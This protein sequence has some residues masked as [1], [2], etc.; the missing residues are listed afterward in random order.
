MAT[1]N[2]VLICIGCL[3]T[4]CLVTSIF[5]IRQN[6]RQSERIAELERANAEF[7]QRYADC[8]RQLTDVCNTLED[9]N[10]RAGEIARSMAEQLD[11]D[12]GNIEKTRTLVRL[13]REE[14]K[15]LEDSYTSI[16]SSVRRDNDTNSGG[17]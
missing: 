10:R 12:A 6:R 15:V 16:S 2:W 3:L 14:I 13:L 5:F 17:M 1:R 11:T 7:E 9:N 8:N 4:G